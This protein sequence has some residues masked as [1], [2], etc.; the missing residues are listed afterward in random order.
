MR[1]AGQ[2]WRWGRRWLAL[3]LVL[4]PVAEAWAVQPTAAAVAAFEAYTARVE[5]RLTAQHRAPEGFCLG[6]PGSG[7]QIVRMDGAAPAGALVHHWRGTAFAAGVRAADFERMLRDFGD[8]PEAFAPEVTE[9]HILHAQG[10]RMEATM[11]V[12]Q[13]HGV[14]VVLDS[15]YA[16]QFGRLD[17]GHG[18]S[19]SRSTRVV[20]VSGA[21]TVA[22]RALSGAEEHGFLWRMNTYWSWA[23]RDGGLEIEVESVSLSRSIP[24]GLGWLVGPF[25]ESIPRESLEFTLRAAIGAVTTK[26]QHKEAE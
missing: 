7:M 26:T 5:A 3:A 17:A 14:T 24:A 8:Y 1:I 20:E 19:V 23:E 4:L 9:A 16:V 12:R 22:E 18:W 25:V 11:R 10:D 2:G 15:T 6:R 21:G 13:R